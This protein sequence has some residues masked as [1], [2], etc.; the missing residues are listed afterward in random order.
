MNRLAM[1]L[2]LLAFT[3]VACVSAGGVE[4]QR[5][6][7]PDVRGLGRPPMVSVWMGGGSVFRQ[8]DRA[9]VYFRADRSAYVTVMRIDTDGRLSVLYPS[10]AHQQRRVRGGQTVVVHSRS[11]AF[12]VND[13]TGLGYVFAIASDEPF[14]YSRIARGRNWEYMHVRHTR[15]DPFEA[16]HD[17]AE[18]IVWD[19]RT[20]YSLD[21][22][23]YH[24]G[25]RAP[26]PRYMCLDVPRGHDPYLYPCRRFATVYRASPHRYGYG[27]YY[28]YSNRAVYVR[29]PAR[30]PQIEQKP[31]QAAP[32]P[33]TAPGNEIERRRREDDAD[34]RRSLPANQPRRVESESEREGPQ[35]VA[36]APAPRR[37]IETRERGQT[38]QTPADPRATPRR[39]T[40][41]QRTP[42]VRRQNNPPPAVA[43]A[44]AAAPRRDESAR[45]QRAAPRREPQASE[46]REEQASQPANT[47][48][49]RRRTPE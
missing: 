26:Y 45:P 29:Q 17:L 18:M 20:P 24:V 47:N 11:G 7:L 25:R 14:D 27:P 34:V 2:G 40:E 42:A 22:A 13:R 8:G 10:H 12:R 32:P 33:V 44:P 1:T 39:E 31:P 4:A 5:R 46:G 30:Y 49:R 48:E 28:G 43:P 36:P 3:S 21:F 15:Y 9:P 23:E 38:G 37:D 41:P 16:M 35:T 6:P 19:R